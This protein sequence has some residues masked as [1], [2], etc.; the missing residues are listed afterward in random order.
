MCGSGIAAH[1]LVTVYKLEGRQTYA[2]F[3][4]AGFMGALAGMSKPGI[5]VSEANLDNAAVAF[6]GLAWPLRLR[7]VMGRAT[8][9]SG[10]EAVWAE[11]NNT[12]AFNFLLGS[13]EDAQGVALEAI[14]GTTGAMCSPFPWWAYVTLC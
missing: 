5:T 13:A 4:Y 8:N 9:L 14:S 1:K 7:N 12:A 11:T 2:T 10:A 6:D 3:G